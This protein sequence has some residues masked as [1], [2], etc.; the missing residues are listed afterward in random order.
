MKL[1]GV[2]FFWNTRKNF[3]LSLVLVLVLKFKALYFLG[4]RAA[5]RNERRRKMQ[6]SSRPFIPPATQAN[7]N[8]V[9]EQQSKGKNWSS[10]P[11]SPLPEGSL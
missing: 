9:T 7:F 5:K 4:G 10:S 11:L 8:A 3:K 1:S 6:H 2:S